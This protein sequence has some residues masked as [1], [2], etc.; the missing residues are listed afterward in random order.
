MSD[1]LFTR[2]FNY[3]NA[4]LFNENITFNITVPKSISKWVGLHHNI[5]NLHY[6]LS[7]DINGYKIYSFRYTGTKYIADVMFDDE[8]SPLLVLLVPEMLFDCDNSDIRKIIILIYTNILNYLSELLDI[9]KFM[10]LKQI[11]NYAETILPIYTIHKC[12]AI[13][14]LEIYEQIKD[15]IRNKIDNDLLKDLQDEI[16]LDILDYGTIIK[17]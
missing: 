5:D 12:E 13:P 6:N 7:I 17:K 1:R 10:K 8:G 4:V 2:I 16:N 14:V 9:C 11:L 3:V 15:N